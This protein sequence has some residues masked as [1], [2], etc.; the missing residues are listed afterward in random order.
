MLVGGVVGFLA[1]HVVAVHRRGWADVRG[2]KA[3]VVK[4][5]KAAWANMWDT[6]KIGALALAVVITAG[7][8]L[9]RD[10]TDHKTTPLVPATS[11]R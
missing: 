7:W 9:Y 8:W 3:E 4:R 6:A 1:G 5:R 10:V 2:A 11:R